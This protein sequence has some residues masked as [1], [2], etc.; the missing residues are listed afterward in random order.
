M[1]VNLLMA[2]LKPAKVEEVL[3]VFGR[4][5]HVENSSRKQGIFMWIYTRLR[6]RV[7]Q[8]FSIGRNKIIFGNAGDLVN[9]E[10]M[11]DIEERWLSHLFPYYKGGY[12]SS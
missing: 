10:Q 3:T 8:K 1:I 5:F 4:E 12:L 9:F 6:Y 2:D 7:D 11:V